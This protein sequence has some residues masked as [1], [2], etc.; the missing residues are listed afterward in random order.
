MHLLT[1]KICKGARHLGDHFQML[2]QPQLEKKKYNILWVRRIENKI[3]S[4]VYLRTDYNTEASVMW[5]WNLHWLVLSGDLMKAWQQILSWQIHSDC[6]SRL[7][8]R[9]ASPSLQISGSLSSLLW[10]S[11]QRNCVKPTARN[12]AQKGNSSGR[13]RD[14]ETIFLLAYDSIINNK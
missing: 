1:D 6:T 5:L 12:T 7:C 4:N 8:G 11:S 2:L 13:R 3:S 14:S 10:Q 9:S